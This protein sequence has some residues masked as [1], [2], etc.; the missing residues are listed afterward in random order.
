VTD[1]P[2]KFIGLL[3]KSIVGV[4]IEITR[5]GGKF[6]MS[7]EVKKEDR[8]GV[9]EGFAGIGEDEMKDSVQKWGQK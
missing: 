6:K 8:E 3:K 9:I 4:S 2:D 1:A 5:L 7:Q